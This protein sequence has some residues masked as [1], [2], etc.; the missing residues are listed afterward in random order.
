[1]QIEWY[2]GYDSIRLNTRI[3]CV[4]TFLFYLYEKFQPAGCL[5]HHIIKKAYE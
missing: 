2:R 5:C 3:A 4:G 1:M